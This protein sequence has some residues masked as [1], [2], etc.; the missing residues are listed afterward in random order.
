MGKRSLFIYSEMIM[1]GSGDEVSTRFG[2]REFYVDAETGFFL[3][4][5]S[6]PLRGVSRHQD[7]QGKDGQ[8]ARKIKEKM[9]C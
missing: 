2:I 6:Y 3:N 4:Q 9:R 7:R 8:S 5:E 1:E